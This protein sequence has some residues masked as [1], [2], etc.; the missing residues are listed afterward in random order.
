[1]G[2]RRCTSCRCAAPRSYTCTP[3]EAAPTTGLG[4][5]RTTPL[6]RLF[7]VMRTCRLRSPAT[8]RQSTASLTVQVVRRH[9]TVLVV[10][11]RNSCVQRGDTHQS[12][13]LTSSEA[14]KDDRRASPARPACGVAWGLQSLPLAA[15]LLLPEQTRETDG[16]TSPGRPFA[17]QRVRTLSSLSAQ[18][19]DDGVL[20]WGAHHPRRTA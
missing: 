10:G 14:G 2:P 16:R 3:R 8:L 17:T 9:V 20:P 6:T 19:H 13:V 7:P 15:P 4:N 1:M 18:G 12:L 11:S 5:T